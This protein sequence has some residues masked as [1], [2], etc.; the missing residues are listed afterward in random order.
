MIGGS[1]LAIPLFLHELEVD[2][3]V[4]RKLQVTIMGFLFGMIPGAFIGSLFHK[5]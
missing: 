3:S 5:E 2:T 1:L 4:G